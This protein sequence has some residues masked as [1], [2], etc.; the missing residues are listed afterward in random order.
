MGRYSNYGC[1]VTKT[2]VH[3]T[4][5]RRTNRHVELFSFLASTNP[6]YSIL[7]ARQIHDKNQTSP[8]PPI[9][10]VSKTALTASSHNVLSNPRRPCTPLNR[11]RTS[12][13]ALVRAAVP[14]SDPTP[15]TT[16]AAATAAAD[17]EGE[18]DFGQRRLL[19]RKRRS[20]ASA[21][22]ITQRRK[23]GAKRI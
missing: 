13:T 1:Y 23:R 15:A 9:V 22:R 3:A 6:Y 21:G 7:A 2:W 19:R 5:E 12:A 10:T 20:I 16:D 18:I 4:I 11:L 17:E 8:R 14:N